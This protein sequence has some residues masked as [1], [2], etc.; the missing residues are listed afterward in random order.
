MA[1]TYLSVVIPTYNEEARIGKTLDT[2]VSFLKSQHY[3]SELVIVDDGSKDH[4]LTVIRDQLKDYP[5]ELIVSPENAGK[6]SAVKQGMLKSKGQFVLFT[7]ADLSTP[8]EEINKFLPYL[9]NGYDVVIGSRALKESNVK[10]HQNFLREGMGKIFN[11]IARLCA[12]RGIED[13]QCGFKSF[14]Q[15]A[16]KDLFSM[17]K[18]HGFAFDAEI[19]YLAQKRNYKIKEEPITWC[20]SPQSRVRILR[21][22]I[23]MFFEILSIRWLHRNT[24]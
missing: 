10:R 3:S 22:P 15:T 13:S 2:V 9:E 4:T 5:H 23:K 20:N 18:L 19:L 6:G 16:A 24:L 21:D 8:I 14:K 17:Q 12:F 11:R 7:D 1:A